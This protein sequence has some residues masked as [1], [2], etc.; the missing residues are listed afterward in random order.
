MDLELKLRHSFLEV[1]KSFNLSHLSST[2]EKIVLSCPCDGDGYWNF[3]L[4][5]IWVAHEFG[6]VSAG[7][8]RMPTTGKGPALISNSNDTSKR[9]CCT[10][11][12]CMSCIPGMCECTACMYS[13]QYFV[14]K[15]IDQ[16]VDNL[17]SFPH[18]LLV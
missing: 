15:S 1:N 14:E 5:E 8:H 12:F 17:L 10:V 4:L 11:H 13:Q 7:A 2:N 6:S 3:G 16:P 9:G 18:P